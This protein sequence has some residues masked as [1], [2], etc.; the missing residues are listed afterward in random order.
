MSHPLKKNLRGCSCTSG[1][2]PFIPTVFAENGI[3]N[4]V[5]GV[6][7]EVNGV[8]GMN[9]HTDGVNGVNG[10]ADAAT[11]PKPSLRLSF[12]EYRRISNLLVVHLRRVEEGKKWRLLS[13]YFNS[14]LLLSWP[15]RWSFCAAE[16]E[17]ELKKS[18]L[19][20]WYLQE[21]ESEIDSEEALVGKKALIEKVL[22][23]LVHYV[24]V[25]PAI[26]T[27][28][29]KCG[30][31][32]TGFVCFY[33]DHILIELS[34]AGLKGSESASTEEEPLLVVNP[35]YILEDWRAL[36]VRKLCFYRLFG[37]HTR[38]FLSFQLFF[39]LLYRCLW[40]WEN[41]AIVK[42]ILYINC[43]LISY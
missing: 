4:G 27:L 40:E 14:S 12:N 24:S 19:V 37:L 25:C 10:H 28:W 26:A 17:E 32:L 7:G 15:L 20:N 41:I 13:R 42:W 18:S 16:E 9:G 34:Q 38:S 11:Q 35:N 30:W 22:H 33:Q 21:I 6:N 3:P 29:P 39:S 31:K 43:S 36:V 2:V 8:N 23:R 1:E 5:N